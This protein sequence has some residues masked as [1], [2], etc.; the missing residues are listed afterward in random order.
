MLGPDETSENDSLIREL[1]NDDFRAA[2]DHSDNHHD[3]P[4]DDFPTARNQCDNNYNDYFEAV[5][6]AS[7]QLLACMGGITRRMG[8]ELTRQNVCRAAITTAAPVCA[9][10]YNGGAT[11]IS[12]TGTPLG[13]CFHRALSLTAMSDHRHS[14]QTYDLREASGWKPAA[15]TEWRKLSYR[16][17]E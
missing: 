13:C 2:H 1:K 14:T 5:S 9:P 17:T 8:A 10:R 12:G 16:W 4:H 3:D 11:T 6:T 7:V 15:Y